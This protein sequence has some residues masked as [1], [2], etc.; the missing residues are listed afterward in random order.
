M[1]LAGLTMDEDVP[2]ESSSMLWRRGKILNSEKG[3][4]YRLDLELTV[5]GAELLVRGY[6]APFW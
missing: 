2:V 3:Q 1:I 6:W 5:Q 4:E